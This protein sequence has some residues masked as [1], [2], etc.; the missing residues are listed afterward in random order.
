MAFFGQDTVSKLTNNSGET[1]NTYDA[2]PAVVAAPNGRIGLVW[3]RELEQNGQYNYNIYFAVLDVSGSIVY[4]PVNLTNNSSWESNAVRLYSPH[5]TATGDNR[6]VL[7]WSRIQ[8]FPSCS[9]NDCSL[10]D[11]YY[12]VRDTS[13]NAVRS[14]TR[15]TFDTIGSSSEGYY[16]PNL[17]TLSGNRVLLTWERGSEAD[18]YY[19]VLNSAGD[20]VKNK[21]NLTNDGYSSYD[22]VSDAVQLSDGKIVVGWYGYT[23][24]STTSVIRFS[25]LDTSYNRIVAPITLDNPAAPNGNSYVSIAADNAGHAILTWMDY[26]SNN[27]HRNLYYALVDGS[28]SILTPPMIFRTTQASKIETSYNGYGNTSY[29][30]SISAGVDTA[31]WPIISLVGGP[32]GGAASIGVNYANHGQTIGTGVVITATLGPELT[33]LNDTS[34]VAPTIASNK[35]TWHLPDLN[36]LDHHQ[37][38]LYATVPST[39]TIGTRY[40]VTLTIAAN[41]SDANPSDNT[42][43]LEVMAAIQI[44]LP[45]IQ[46]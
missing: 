34:G 13:G 44:F 6:F 12:A 29:S 26:V 15:L 35:V 1:V 25:V 18:I 27:N 24:G 36:F 45:I 28:G 7:T 31:I 40:P 22:Y 21:T 19:A 8:Y 32:P 9:S 38:T 4:G 20:I 17:T 43:N 10:Y 5:I 2:S 42:A 3:Y 11:I 16:W 39:A 23:G 33:Y 30:S 37:F 46:R 14:I 41:E